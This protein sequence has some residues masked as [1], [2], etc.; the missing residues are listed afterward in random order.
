MAQK[1]MKST[2]NPINGS[3]TD[4][5]LTGESKSEEST[6]PRVDTRLPAPGRV[7]SKE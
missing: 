2:G 4:R 1:Y 5:R 6:L 3:R 7:L